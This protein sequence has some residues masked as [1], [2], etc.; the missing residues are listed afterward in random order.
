[1]PP[2]Q[3]GRILKG[4]QTSKAE[5][6]NHGRSLSLRRRSRGRSEAYG[7]PCPSL[8]KEEMGVSIFYAEGPM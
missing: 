1:M 6:S 3:T 2:D 8:L 7:K 5:G 4:I